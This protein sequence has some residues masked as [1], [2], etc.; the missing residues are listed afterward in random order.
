MCF[1]VIALGLENVM[2]IVD[3]YDYSIFC[4]S[5]FNHGFVSHRR[6]LCFL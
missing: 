4:N 5:T 2:A 6:S 1:F 3:F